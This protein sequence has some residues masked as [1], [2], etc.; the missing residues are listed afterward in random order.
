MEGGEKN[1]LKRHVYARQIRVS[2]EVDLAGVSKGGTNR[3]T[4]QLVKNR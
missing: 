3:D 1:R 2:Q 4:E